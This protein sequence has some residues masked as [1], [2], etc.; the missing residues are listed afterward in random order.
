MPKKRHTEA[1]VV[2]IL[3][4]A[5]G[6]LTIEEICRK[7][8]ITRNTFYRWRKLYGSLEVDQARELK[9]LREENAKLKRKCAD[10]LLENEDL[11]FINSK[12]W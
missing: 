4:E 6:E 8:G 2:A 10:L 9:R 12:K 7:H 5:D 1:Q 3:R 11:K